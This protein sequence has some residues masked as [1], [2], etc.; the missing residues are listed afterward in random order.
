[1]EGLVYIVIIVIVAIFALYLLTYWL[2]KK[3]RLSEEMK[4][5]LD[6]SAMDYGVQKLVLV[7][8]K[9]VPTKELKGKITLIPHYT[10]DPDTT[11]VRLEKGFWPFKKVRYV[12]LLV[13][14]HT[15]ITPGE[16]LYIATTSFLPLGNTGFEV[17]PNFPLG[18]AIKEHGDETLLYAMKEIADSY[19][20]L[21]G[22]LIAINLTHQEAMERGGGL[23]KMMSNVKD[24]VLGAVP[25]P[26][27][28][29]R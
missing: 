8:S 19:G 9:G 1:M 29:P 3:A 22:R 5:H 26:Q 21:A 17:T 2:A 20:A 14:E 15:D 23:I 24:T 18:T 7:G 6:K 16:P 4:K 27:K 12:K 28:P 13:K 25:K 11:L 10:K